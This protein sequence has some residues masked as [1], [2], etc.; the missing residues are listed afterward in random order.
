MPKPEK[1]QPEEQVSPSDLLSSLIDKA[2]SA[3]GEGATKSGSS[4]P[5]YII[6]AGIAVLI[7][8]ITGF[9]LVRARRKVARL[10]SELRLKEEEKVRLV[11]NAKLTLSKSNRTRIKAQIVEKQLEIKRIER[12]MKELAEANAVRKASLAKLTSWDDLVIVDRR[13]KK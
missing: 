2:T 10:A 4:M 12:G 13:E 6:I 9:M 5:V 1:D 11:E 7:I 8:S 3:G